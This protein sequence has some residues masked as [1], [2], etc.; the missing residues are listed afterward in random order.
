MP[1]V[2]V[3]GE[4]GMAQF[5]NQRGLKAVTQVVMPLGVLSGCLV[6]LAGQLS[7]SFWSDLPGHL[8]SVPPLIWLGVAAF[9]LLSFLSLG[10]Y[11]AIAHRHLRTDTPSQV[12]RLSGM[13]AIGVA[14]TLGFGLL[15]GAI[16]RW[17]LLPHLSLPQALSVS[18]FVSCSFIVGWVFVTAAACL[19]LPAPGWAKWPAALCLLG[20]PVLAYALFR[21]PSLRLW[22]WNMRLP[23]LKSAAGIVWWS[24]LDTAAAAAALWLLLPAGA[25]ISFAA[26]LPLFLL[27]TGMALITNTPGG[28]GPF[29]L[30]LLGLIPTLTA[31][32]LVQSIIAYRLVY[33][34]I[35]ASLGALALLRPFRVATAAREAHVPEATLYNAKRS[36]V[37][38][39]RQN[40]GEIR[41]TPDGLAAIW[42]T[43]QT[44]CAMF[45]P[46]SGSLQA[47][48]AETER[49][50]RKT[51]RW[52]LLYKAS[53]QD[54][55]RAR[56]MGWSVLHI[57]D[58]AILS[59]QT[60]D[61]N[62]PKRRTLRRKL[63]HAEKAGLRVEVPH[64]LPL[65]AMADIDA[66]WCARH[67]PARGGTMGRYDP[68]HV[69]L[70]WV[71]MAYIDDVPVAYVSFFMSRHEWSL[72]LMRQSADAPDGTMHRLVT[73]AL[74]AAKQAGIASLSLA[75]TPA[76]P[77]PRSAVWRKVS[78]IVVANAGGTG[79]RQFKSAFAPTWQ[80][81]YAAAPGPLQLAL[82]LCDIAREVH[83]PPALP[84][85]SLNK[86]HH[87][88]ENYELDLQKRA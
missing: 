74:A 34:A 68:D 17:R 20:A 49:L 52:P 10:K 22:R 76:C 57:A 3:M 82:G 15:T 55:L 56:S 23:S 79:L 64:I 70:Q 28:V 72:D 33:Y 67:G 9:T 81:R 66:A 38:M 2:V 77:D 83:N 48:L 71:C 19:I 51:E 45:A 44:V 29:E 58:D 40:G 59:P 65:R 78:Q 27:A 61:L 69:A 46:V 47:C 6:L 36:E 75:A 24:F 39:V 43:A 5:I 7:A 86:P 21:W 85:T 35:P 60:F 88:D 53:A 73:E 87:L 50:A 41:R 14:Q 8:S 26:F 16:A 63:R 80:P 37:A 12:A 13:A 31:D 32:A 62:V 42:P 54:A 30:V 84:D 25:E 1:G 18:A 4:P 11:D